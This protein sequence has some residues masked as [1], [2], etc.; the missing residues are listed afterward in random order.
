M[1]PKT[2]EI[3]PEKISDIDWDCRDETVEKCKDFRN[4]ETKVT[5]LGDN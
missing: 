3:S 5:K 1:E 2:K 4:I